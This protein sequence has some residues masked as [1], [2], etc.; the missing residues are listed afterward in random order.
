M[1]RTNKTRNYRRWIVISVSIGVLLAALVIGIG[2][3][4]TKNQIDPS[5]LAV[6]EQGDI[7]RSVVAT[8]KIEPLAK[9]DVKS[10]A[11]VIVKQVLVEYGDRVTQGQVLVELD[12]EELLARLREA[13]ASLLAAEAARQASQASHERN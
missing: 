6:V 9:V 2:A 12:R 11:S 8:G 3:M 4:R 13:R 5:K 1:N 10:K 7:A